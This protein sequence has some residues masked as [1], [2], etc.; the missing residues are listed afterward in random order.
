VSTPLP[1]R[2]DSVVK[3]RSVSRAVAGAGIAIALVAGIGIGYAAAPKTATDED[4]ASPATASPASSP[5]TP[6]SPEPETS[7]PELSVYPFEGYPRVVPSSDVPDQMQDY[8]DGDQMIAVAPGVWTQFVPGVTPE[9]AAY[10]GS[11]IGYCAAVA[12]AE[13]E[14]QSTQGSTC[15]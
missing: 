15:W 6:F 14:L 13:R 5:S 12:K 2:P 1:P 10:T 9:E 3:K 4:S 7:S 8:V 11:F